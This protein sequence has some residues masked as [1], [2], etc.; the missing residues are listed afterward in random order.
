MQKM[1]WG[2]E[3]PNV[4]QSL[5]TLADVLRQ[6]GKLNQAEALYREFAPPDNHDFEFRHKAIIDRFGRYPHR[7]EVLG[8]MSTAEE[9]EFL[10]QPGSR[11]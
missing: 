10:R 9:I 1:L 5:H 11:F 3:H 8:R 4:A 6:E 2:D 7:N